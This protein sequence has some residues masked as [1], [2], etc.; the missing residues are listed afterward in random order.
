[1]IIDGHAAIVAGGASGLGLATAKMLIARGAKVAI[2]DANA[3]KGTAAAKDIGAVFAEVDITDEQSILDGMAVARERNGGA[4]ILAN[5]AG[6]GGL[7]IR[8]VGKNGAYPMD[9]FRRTVEINYIGAFNITRLVAAEIVEQPA[10]VRGERG[11][12]INTGSANAHDH[13][14]GNIAYN[15]SKAATV[16][17]T[18]TLARDLAPK[19]VRAMAISPGNFE[20]PMLMDGPPELHAMLKQIIPFPNDRFGA[21]EDFAAMVCHICENIMLNGET[22]RLDAAVRHHQTR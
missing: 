9:V 19:G 2:F 17:M 10:L 4:R 3:D 21:A 7:P 16:A 12:V 14:V 1:M 11:V 8:T 6:I 20:T 15:S 5:T 13:P 22:I 18:L